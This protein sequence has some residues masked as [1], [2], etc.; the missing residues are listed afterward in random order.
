MRVRCVVDLSITSPGMLPAQDPRY[1]DAIIWMPPRADERGALPGV[2][3]YLAQRE[4]L[5]S[6]RSRRWSRPS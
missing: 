1:V 2:G 6:A 4:K 3:S 5:R